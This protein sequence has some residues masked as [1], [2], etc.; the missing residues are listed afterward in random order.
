M[1]G[2]SLALGG[3]GEP[4]ADSAA[5][6]A[7]PGKPVLHTASPGVSYEG[8][9]SADGAIGH[10]LGIP[11]A[12]APV[13]EL[14][15][16]APQP[17]S[18]APGRYAATRFS[19]ACM[20]GRHM[21]RWYRGVVESF[22]GD[23]D[24]FPS[25]EFDEDCL[26]LNIWRPEGAA[27][28]LPVL[29]YFHG[30][31]NRGGWAYEPNYI[32]EAL[33]RQGLIVVTIPY[34]LGVFG[35]LAHPA[36]AER[37]FGLLDAIAGLQWL[38]DNIASAGGD[39]QR[40]TIMGESA[41][42]GLVQYLL[43]APGAQGLFQRAISQSYGHGVT[44]AGD[45][46]PQLAAGLALTGALQ[47]PADEAGINTLRQLP[48]ETIL[49]AAEMAYGDLYFE[50]VIDEATLP[51]SLATQI[52]R[53]QLA[54]VALL[55]GS[56]LNEW[57]MYL[58]DGDRPEQ[59]LDQHLGRDGDDQGIRD[60]VM[61]E[62]ALEGDDLAQLDRLTSAADFDCPTLQLAAAIRRSGAG[63]WVYHFTRQRPGELAASM[64]AY[65]GAELPYVFDT[66]DDW[67]PTD[68]ADRELGDIMM[69]YWANFARSGDPNGPGLPWWQAFDREAPT[70]QR[71]DRNIESE[72]HRSLALC[73]LLE[74]AATEQQR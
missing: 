53:E 5:P 29:V 70:V 69:R 55:A 10:F 62:L 74:T 71:L 60:A 72:V 23:P 26:Y 12:R 37:N 3:C 41:G 63:A 34:R 61:A 36:L 50:A 4:P 67:L 48:A 22:G 8:G 51:F 56:N 68:P 65:H 57:R 16:R 1:L 43:V 58:A 25:P 6:Q 49:D 17:L 2:L 52:A 28:P 27:E 54:P 44:S 73:E 42:A 24:S 45:P 9:L 13:N 40:V 66:H 19:A 59:W 64:G 47:L 38:A 35:F 46:S 18:V 14:R 39:P 32:G 11:F 15:W 30:G 31:S 21:I 33:A 7:G 20:Q